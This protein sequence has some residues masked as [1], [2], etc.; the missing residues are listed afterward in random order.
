MSVQAV[1]SDAASFDLGPHI[2]AGC[3]QEVKAAREVAVK[4]REGDQLRSLAKGYGGC[5]L[6]VRAC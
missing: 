2:L 3:I 6:R 4:R 5:G 1:C